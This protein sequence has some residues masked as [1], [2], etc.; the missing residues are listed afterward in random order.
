MNQS[1]YNGNGDLKGVIGLKDKAVN[2][3]K[4]LPSRVKPFLKV[5]LITTMVVFGVM[6]Y[7]YLILKYIEDNADASNQIL[8]V[9][10][11]SPATLL[12]FSFV[13]GYIIKSLINYKGGKNE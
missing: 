12:I 7:A 8:L 11:Y 2:Y 10:Y 5:Q 3:L 9:I 6:F 13:L 1:K 4:N